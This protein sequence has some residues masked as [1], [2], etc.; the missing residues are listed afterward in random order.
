MYLNMKLKY[1]PR[2][3]TTEQSSLSKQAQL[4]C[5]INWHKHSVKNELFNLEKYKSMEKW[6]NIMMFGCLL[7][8]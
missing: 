1:T 4:T 6:Q 8:S 5:K 2:P 7:K 3:D